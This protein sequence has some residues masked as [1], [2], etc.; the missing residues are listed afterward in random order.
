MKK[1]TNDRWDKQKTNNKVIDLIPTLSI[2]TLNVIKCEY[3]N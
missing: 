1:G 3:P 2:V